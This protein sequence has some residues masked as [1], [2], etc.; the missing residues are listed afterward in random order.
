MARATGSNERRGPEP[1]GRA[2]RLLAAIG[3][4]ARETTR[5]PEWDHAAEAAL[6]LIQSAF[7]ADSVAL[8]RAEAEEQMLHLTCQRGLSES[9]ISA[10]GTIPFDAPCPVGRSLRENR[11][12][13]VEDLAQAAPECRATSRWGDLGF[14]SLVVAPMRVAGRPMGVMVCATRS[15]RHY[16]CNELHAL[17]A[18]AEILSLKLDD[19]ALHDSLRELQQQR[20]ELVR[21]FSHDLRSPL[22]AVQGQAQFLL[23]MLGQTGQDGRLSQSA[24]AIYTCA[25]RMDAMIQDLVDMVRAES[26]PLRVSR[27]RIRL[28]SFLSDL[29]QKG[30][31]G[32]DTSRVR[33][34]V[35]ED[36]PQVWADPDRLE[37]AISSLLSNAL[38]RT[39]PD[40]EILVTAESH[41]R[42]VVISVIDR[43]PEIPPE[44]LHRV[45]HRD[46]MAGAT[47]KAEG[48]GL[49]VT[50]LLV[51]AM[52]GRIWADS[53]VGK[54]TSF[55]FTLPR[56]D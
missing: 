35:R 13:V 52:G 19:A 30:T 37:R 31:R 38:R 54:G 22:T 29:K 49:Y 12:Q 5:R 8:W 53:E 32:L 17:L 4:I 7:E 48:P 45:F 43:G 41:D 24:D 1:P 51:E 33:L 27:T 40:T 2:E 56:A 25:R 55:S 26:R 42:E 10:L 15:P 50:R 44:E 9:A 21:M 14:R 6:R 28:D 39:H 18:I 47:R 16:E 36:L 34:E 23:R 20:E 46:P 3:R 11:P